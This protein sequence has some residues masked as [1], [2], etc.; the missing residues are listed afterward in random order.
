[1]SFALSGLGREEGKTK[2]ARKDIDRK[3]EESGKPFDQGQNTG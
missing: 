2:K 1:M 3:K